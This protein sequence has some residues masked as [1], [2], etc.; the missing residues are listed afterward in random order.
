MEFTEFKNCDANSAAVLWI[1]LEF[2]VKHGLVRVGRTK[3]SVPL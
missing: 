2:I 3:G 1:W